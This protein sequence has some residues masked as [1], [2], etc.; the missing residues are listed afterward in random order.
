MPPAI[1]T[2]EQT[3]AL[4][5]GTGAARRTQLEPHSLIEG[6]LGLA[7]ADRFT[8]AAACQRYFNRATPIETILA[9]QTVA[10]IARTFQPPQ[11]GAAA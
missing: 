10:D 7:E 11:P 6:D 3:I 9:W 1:E 8:I 2:I 4:I 5:V